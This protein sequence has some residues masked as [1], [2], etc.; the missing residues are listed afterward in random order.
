MFLKVNR[1]PEEEG[2]DT[3]YHYVNF[4]L[5]KTVNRSAEYETMLTFID[6]KVLYVEESMVDIE[7][8]LLR[9]GM[10]VAPVPSHQQ[11]KD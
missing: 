4:D 8:E 11:P 9:L 5:V 1:C 6:G 10:M 7:D 3:D 2:D